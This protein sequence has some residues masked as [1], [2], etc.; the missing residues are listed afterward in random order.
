MEVNRILTTLVSFGGWQPHHEGLVTY[1]LY[2][3]YC[4]SSLSY[5]LTLS[6]LPPTL[7]FDWWC[8]RFL[9]VFLRFSVKSYSSLSSQ[10]YSLIH[11]ICLHKN[12][13]YVVDAVRSRIKHQSSL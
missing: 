4:H 11:R 6:I 9:Y 8:R 10:L 2:H 13:V 1:D 12:F 5:Y 3:T 7:S